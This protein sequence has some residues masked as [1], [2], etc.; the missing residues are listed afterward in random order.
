LWTIQKAAD[1]MPELQK[2]AQGAT[3]EIFAWGDMRVLKLFFDKMP[4]GMA[5]QEADLTNAVRASDFPA[6][7]AYEVIEVDGREGI[8]YERLNGESFLYL[9]ETKIWRA[10]RLLRTMGEIHAELHT[11]QAVD[12]I[13]ALRL[14]L[15]RKLAEA[16]FLSDTVKAKLLEHLVSLPDGDKICHCDFHPLNILQC[17]SQ[18]VVIDWNDVKRGNPHADVARTLIILTERPTVQEVGWLLATLFPILQRV[19]INAYLQRYCH[20]TRTNPDEIYQWMPIVA[21]ARLREPSAKHSQLQALI[22][23][24]YQSVI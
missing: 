19:M 7:T 4:R 9:L 12:T 1:R 10:P 8:V 5:Q 2:I 18:A 6:P 23:K 21:A 13:P 17:A 22:K 14:S 24:W 20:L 3:A 15:E 16:P 11:H